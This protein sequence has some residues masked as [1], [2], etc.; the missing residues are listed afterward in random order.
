MLLLYDRL[1]SRVRPDRLP[2]FVFE[3]TD[4]PL[5]FR[6][7]NHYATVERTRRFNDKEVEWTVECPL[8]V[9]RLLDRRATVGNYSVLTVSLTGIII[10]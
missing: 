10:T 2:S 8:L 3:R 9:R 5:T 6:N 7:P 1:H 4:L